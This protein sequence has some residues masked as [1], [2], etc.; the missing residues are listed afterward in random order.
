MKTVSDL[1]AQARAQ[2]LDRLD[3]QLLLSHVLKRARSWVIANDDALP[4]L[5][6]TQQLLSFFHRRARGEPI[7]W[8]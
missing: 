7:A 2:G 4:S 1:M 6:Q 8:C 5:G 3:V